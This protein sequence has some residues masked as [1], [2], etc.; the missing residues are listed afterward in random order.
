MFSIARPSR[1][2]NCN[3][4]QL[5]VRPFTLPRSKETS[6]CAPFPAAE[7]EKGCHELSYSARKGLTALYN[8]ELINGAP[9]H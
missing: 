5:S 7:R 1:W 9:G 8:R 6:L 4:P 3:G 2:S